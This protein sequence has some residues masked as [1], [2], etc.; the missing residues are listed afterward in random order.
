VLEV[1][2]GDRVMPT[3]E[4]HLRPVFLPHPA[5]ADFAGRI[6]SVYGGVSQIGQYNVVVLNK[7]EREGVESGQVMTVYRKGDAVMDPYAKEH[8][9]GKAAERGM[10][11]R[12]GD[13][14]GGERKE[15]VQLP[16]EPAGTLMVFRTFDKVSLAL[17]MEAKRPI[18]VLDAVRKPE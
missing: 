12:L 8:R 7:G 13:F 3:D 4:Q 10:F 1:L 2:P 15:A 11:Q 14:F 16:D 6:I 18:H 9:A 17:V 5:K